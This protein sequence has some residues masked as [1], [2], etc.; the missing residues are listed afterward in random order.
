MADRRIEEASRWFQQALYDLKAASWNLE[1][2]FHNTVS[3][4]AQ[5]SGEK[6][7][8]ALSSLAFHHGSSGAE[9]EIR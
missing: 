5:Q 1:G 4:L 2:G 3:F 6:A 7:L 9:L 8:K